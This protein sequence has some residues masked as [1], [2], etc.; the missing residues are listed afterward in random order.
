MR[1]SRS[2]VPGVTHCP[3]GVGH[4]ENLKVGVQSESNRSLDREL[5]MLT[6]SGTIHN[7]ST[8]AAK[9]DNIL[10][11]LVCQGLGV[12]VPSALTRVNDNSCA[13][14]ADCCHSL[15]DNS[16]HPTVTI[17]D[18]LTYQLPTAHFFLFYET[19]SLLWAECSI[20]CWDLSRRL[21][22]MSMLL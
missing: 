7:C 8:K 11:P 22:S 4:K 2:D 10:I 12:W 3:G 9:R 14:A 19:L 5:I 1:Y 18:T 13:L 21:Y 17:R 16:Q 15:G 6:M 20:L